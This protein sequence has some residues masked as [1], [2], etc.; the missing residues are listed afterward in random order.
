MPQSPPKMN[1]PNIFALRAARRARSFQTL[2]ES[3]P[4]LTPII[5]ELG[6]SKTIALSKVPA[7]LGER[8]FKPAQA[9][10]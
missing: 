8:V 9:I 3:L 10:M 7:R 4:K 6:T 1:T 2:S 5:S